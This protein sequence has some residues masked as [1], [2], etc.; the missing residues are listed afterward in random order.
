MPER[1]ASARRRPAAPTAQ[2]ADSTASSAAAPDSAQY[3][4]LDD[5]SSAQYASLDDPRVMLDRDIG[6]DLFEPIPPLP[7]TIRPRTACCG[8]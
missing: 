5:V 3:A 7:T 2:T 4:S 8:W 1:P 6:A